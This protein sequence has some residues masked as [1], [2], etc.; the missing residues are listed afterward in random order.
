MEN[1]YEGGFEKIKTDET[2]EY[3]RLLEARIKLHKYPINLLKDEVGKVNSQLTLT[4]DSNNI[5]NQAFFD[6]LKLSDEN[7]NLSH[8]TLCEEFCK[9]NG[10]IYSEA[11]NFFP[12]LFSL[13]E[14]RFWL[15][16][17]I[18]ELE[19]EEEIKHVEISEMKEGEFTTI[20]RIL[21]IQFLLKAA[22]KE[23]QY[24]EQ[25]VNKTKISEFI[26]FLVSKEKAPQDIRDSLIRKTLN[27]TW[28]KEHNVRLENLNFLSNQFKR[29]GL[30]N[31]SDQI[32]SIINQRK[33][34]ER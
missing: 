11:I 33:S 9:K 26:D 20:R 17:K 3:K 27:L 7:K 6:L 29:I 28:H 22:G 21:T 24:E 10:I 31:L 19:L 32:D 5:L 23:I 2:S 34:E 12:K 16:E 25:G 8:I 15:I 1:V 13:Y 30:T 18:N 14:I 4:H